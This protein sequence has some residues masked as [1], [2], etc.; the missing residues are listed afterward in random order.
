MKNKYEVRGEYTAIFLNRKDGTILETLI[1]TEDLVIADKYPNSWKSNAKGKRIY[2]EGKFTVDGNTKYVRLHRLILN[3]RPELVVDHINGNALD[4]R[5]QNLR[6][7][8][9]G[10][11]L[12][13]TF[14]VPERKT[15][16]GI[17][18]V[19]WNDNEQKWQVSIMLKGNTKYIGYYDDINRAKEISLKTRAIF[20]PY[21][22][23]NREIVIS[24]FDPDIIMLRNKL[25]GTPC[26]G[27]D[28]RLKPKLKVNNK[29]GVS[30]VFWNKRREKWS[31]RVKQGKKTLREKTFDNI[32]DAKKYIEEMRIELQ[33]A[34]E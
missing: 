33:G 27:S 29:S 24:E 2:I 28:R 12:Q 3:A 16:S 10:E 30:G 18:N 31:A 15:L 21:S 8:T 1:D 25:F 4:N 22:K 14:V 11:N 6:E 17:K 34:T 23:E 19:Y 13:N 7:V 5:K 9:I 26:I 32:M 20:F